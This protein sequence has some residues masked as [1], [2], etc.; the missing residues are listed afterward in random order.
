MF[1]FPGGWEWG[2]LGQAVHWPQGPHWASW[3]RICNLEDGHSTSHFTHI[4]L[5][6]L[7]CRVTS[8]FIP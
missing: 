3:E 5:F 8:Y 6:M 2:S 4:S 1:L 7:L